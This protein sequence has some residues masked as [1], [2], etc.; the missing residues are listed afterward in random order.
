MQ[1]H[2]AITD[3]SR[4]QR[5]YRNKLR[6]RLF[7]VAGIL[8]TANGVILATTLTD[9]YRL[10]G[11]SFWWVTIAC[12]ALI[13]LF[14]ARSVVNSVAGL[15]RLQQEFDPAHQVRITAR[16][17]EKKTERYGEEDD[18]FYYRI[19]ANDIWFE[20]SEKVYARYEK[21]QTVTLWHTPRA[22]VLVQITAAG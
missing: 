15:M 3:T 4:A 13:V 5:K 19:K 11:N 22:H 21:G 16:I 7:V 17:Q 14:F 20:V 9:E 8:L 18:E 2:D 10:G 12:N 1:P 6:G